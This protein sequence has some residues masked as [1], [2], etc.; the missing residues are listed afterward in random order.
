MPAIFAA[1][2]STTVATPA[3]A[4]VRALIVLLRLSMAWVFLYAASH[5]VFGGFSVSGFLGSTKTFHWLFAPMSVGPLAVILSFAVAWGHLLIGL[6]LLSGLFTRLSAAFGIA[7]ML[8]YWMAHMDFP[9]ISATTNFLLDEHIVYALV[10]GLMIATHAG[11]IFGLDAWA[12]RL[13][14]GRRHR[15]FDWAVA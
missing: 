8:L 9:Y 13:D 12:A 14:E 1:F 5:Q 11:H 2:S 3:S 10:L 6:S 7:L 15:W 4:S